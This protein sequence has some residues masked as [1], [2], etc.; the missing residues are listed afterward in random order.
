MEIA[1]ALALA[2]AVFLLV[3]S[4]TSRGIER[5]RA[6]RFAEELLALR[7]ASRPQGVDRE[8]TTIGTSRSSTAIRI[9][10]PPVDLEGL[11]NAVEEARRPLEEARRAFETPEPSAIASV[12]PAAA[13]RQA[14]AW[15]PV[16]GRAGQCP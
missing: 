6:Q 7:R 13:A 12:D 10:A 3:S 8:D 5:A 15:A 9:L 11:R 14:A 1:L 2:V 4:L 16:A